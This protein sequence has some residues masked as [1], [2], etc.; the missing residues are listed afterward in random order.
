MFTKD[1]GKFLFT[2]FVDLKP[3]NLTFGGNIERKYCYPSLE[4]KNV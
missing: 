2:Q 3:M 1:S 4:E